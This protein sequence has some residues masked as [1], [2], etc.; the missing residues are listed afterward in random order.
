MINRFV[1]DSLKSLIWTFLETPK[2]FVPSLKG[3]VRES[4]AGMANMRTWFSHIDWIKSNECLLLSPSPA[5]ELVLE[6]TV[7]ARIRGSNAF[8]SVTVRIL[9]ILKVSQYNCSLRL[10]TLHRTGIRDGQT[11]LHCQLAIYSQFATKIFKNQPP[12]SPPSPSP[13]K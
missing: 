9:A 6:A 13:Y 10:A 12:L 1:T 4:H 8:S 11:V 2:V 3:A 5:W 7:A